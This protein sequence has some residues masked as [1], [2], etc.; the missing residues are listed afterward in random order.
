MHWTSHS[1]TI[2]RSRSVR[3]RAA[4]R[5]SLSAKDRTV[6]KIGVEC[7]LERVE[8]ALLGAE[9]ETPVLRTPRLLGVH[10]IRPLSSSGGDQLEVF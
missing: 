7:D 5:R 10:P 9:S 2:E 8:R 3:R 1:C 6:H 4:R